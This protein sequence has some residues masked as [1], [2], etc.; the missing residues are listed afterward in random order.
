M[1]PDEIKALHDALH[2]LEIRL[3]RLE[4]LVK[5]GGSLMGVVPIALQLW[6]MWHK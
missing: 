2:A 3:V 1:C 5:I 6:Q 4:A